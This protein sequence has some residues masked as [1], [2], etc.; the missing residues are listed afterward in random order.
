MPNTNDMNDQLGDER[1]QSQ[2]LKEYPSYP[3]A[4]GRMGAMANDSPRCRYSFLLL[5][6][7]LLLH[8]CVVVVVVACV[9][10]LGVVVVACMWFW[11][12]VVY[13]WVCVCVV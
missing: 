10:F 5:L 7:L 8:T 9:C 1:M 6:L 4:S 2:K 11:H 12:V 3:H 13:C